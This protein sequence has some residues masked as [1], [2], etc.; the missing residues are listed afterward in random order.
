MKKVDLSHTN[1]E[2]RELRLPEGIEELT[3]NYT[4]GL[5]RDV[6]DLSRYGQLKKI[7][8]RTCRPSFKEVL[9]PAGCAVDRGN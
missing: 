4:G 8:L 2:F 3:L 9:V 6:L 7:G 5:A 1:L